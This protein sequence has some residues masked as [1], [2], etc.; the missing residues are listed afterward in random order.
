[1]T[2]HTRTNESIDTGI[3]TFT[4]YEYYAHKHLSIRS[5]QSP[6]KPLQVTLAVIPSVA[7]ESWRCKS[8]V[9]TRAVT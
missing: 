5:P 1:M 8:V 2:T 7:E 4:P 6:T 3:V 9:S